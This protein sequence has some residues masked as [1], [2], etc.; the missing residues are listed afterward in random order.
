M[1]DWFIDSIV[2]AIFEGKDGSLS[3]V[4][5]KA[6]KDG[7][8][9]GGVSWTMTVTPQEFIPEHVALFVTAHRLTL[10]DP[11]YY[12][13]WW[14]HNGRIYLDISEHTAS[15]SDAIILGYSRKEIAVWDVFNSQEIATS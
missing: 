11:R 7:Y 5:G 10:V 4:T 1:S 6:P 12:V 13:G 14:T 15:E 3:P 9:V 2:E 8:M